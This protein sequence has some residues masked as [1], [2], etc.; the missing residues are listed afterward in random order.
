MGDSAGTKARQIVYFATAIP[1]LG[2]WLFG[3]DAGVI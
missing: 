1:A 2:G 3:Y